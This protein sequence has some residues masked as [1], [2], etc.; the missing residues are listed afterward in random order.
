MDFLAAGP[1]LAKEVYECAADDGHT[2][3]IIRQ[4]KA[5]LNVRASKDGF[6]GAWAWMLPGSGPLMAGTGPASLKGAAKGAEGVLPPTTTVPLT[7]LDNSQRESKVL[8]APLS[9]R[10]EKPKVSKVL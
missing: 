6:Q 7:P 10:P 1:R 5:A 8:P 2:K 9:N 4:A 3:G